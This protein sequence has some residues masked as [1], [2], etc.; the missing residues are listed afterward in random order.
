MN[1]HVLQSCM[2]EL[3]H[4]AAGAGTL[5]PLPGMGTS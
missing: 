1:Y 3:T 2:H 4:G 5:P